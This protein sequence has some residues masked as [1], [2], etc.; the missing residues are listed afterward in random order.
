MAAKGEMTVDTLPHLV[1]VL[2]LRGAVIRVNRAASRWGLGAVDPASARALP[3]H[4]YL[5]PSCAKVDCALAQVWPRASVEIELDRSYVTQ[6]TDARSGRVL[7]LAVHPVGI[8][9]P[10]RQGAPA[11][12]AV[13]VI[14]DATR[15]SRIDNALRQA[16]SL[17]RSV[18]A[19][20]SSEAV[21]QAA[22]NALCQLL[23]CR[24]VG[25]VVPSVEEGAARVS[26][27]R[28]QAGAR[29]EESSVPLGSVGRDLLAARASDEAMAVLER[30]A[31]V[32]EMRAMGLDVLLPLIARGQLVGVMGVGMER[33][34]GLNGE[35]A[36]I[37]REIGDQLALA[38]AD[39]R[40]LHAV[41]AQRAQ[42]QTL[43]AR[44]AEMQESERRR[45]AR[46]LHDRVGQNLTALGIN[47]NIVR[48]H[49]SDSLDARTESRLAAALKLLEET[50]DHIRDVMAELRP[51]VLD[52]YGLL[53]ALR[54]YSQRFVYFT[55]VSTQ[56]EGEE[57]APPLPQAAEIALFRIM[58]E[59][60][61]NVA[62]HA[63]A[64]QVTVKLGSTEDL[65]WLSIEDNGHGFDIGAARRTGVGWGLTT[66]QERAT[67]VGGRLTVQSVPGE[68]T[69][70]LIEVPRRLDDD[71]SAAV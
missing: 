59:A 62:K 48:G 26:L 13:A 41:S 39:A 34:G 11:G 9:T 36:E 14:R 27:M 23:P 10:G 55:G 60:L 47:L 50:V 66:M 69:Q 54:W 43:A 53:A 8:M 45:L 44:M 1:C 64:R 24:W 46:E 68:G 38:L 3:L 49:L 12:H 40:L 2:D 65:A 5:H 18:L 21:T 63:E 22:L 7:D 37:A 51:A 6:V 4:A 16:R 32:A 33:S 17:S 35:A 52:D 29:V 25:V 28:P 31:P 15:E 58:Q 42:L 61:T 71:T 30:F 19:A 70:V 56:V 67:A 57:I 20:R